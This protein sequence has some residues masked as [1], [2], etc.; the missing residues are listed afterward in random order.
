MSSIREVTQ[1]SRLDL[2]RNSIQQQATQT[3]RKLRQGLTAP[4]IDSDEIDDPESRHKM[5][6]NLLR[7]SAQSG[8]VNELNKQGGAMAG[9][10]AGGA[11]GSV[12]PGPGTAIGVFLGRF[13][14]KKLGVSGI[15]IAGALFIAMEIIITIV[16]L[17]F[18]LQIYC[19]TSIGKTID[20][21]TVSIC[22]SIGLYQTNP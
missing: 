14:G 13:I 2:Q 10:W 7:A 20:T 6:L 9:E 1:Q 11:L 4:R 3:S 16:A 12:L 15:I 22:K 21:G 19:G 17:L 8:V 18:L 5:N